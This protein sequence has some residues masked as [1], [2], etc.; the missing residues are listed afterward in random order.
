MK[1]T[2]LITNLVIALSIFICL[3]QNVAEAQGGQGVLVVDAGVLPNSKFYFLDRFDEWMQENIFTF[4]VSSLRVEAA[5]ANASERVAEAQILNAR[6]LL[7]KQL[8]GQILWGWRKDLFLAANIVENQTEKGSNPVHLIQQ[9]L[10]IIFLGKEALGEEVK[11]N[12]ILTSDDQ[13]KLEDYLW[14]TEEKT[15]SL[16]SGSD[17]MKLKSALETLTKGQIYFVEKNIT[18]RKRKLEVDGNNGKVQFAG[19]E[20]IAVAESGIEQVKKFTENDDYKNA[21]DAIG[22]VRSAIHLSGAGTLLFD[23]AD[24]SDGAATLERIRKA[25]EIITN[26][27][28]L[29]IGLINNA[30]KNLTDKL[31]IRIQE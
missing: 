13:S 26:S 2:R 25:E 29:D 14:E 11:D 23:E 12:I 1:N 6:G 21:L 28:L 20:M 17:D 24:D 7:S 19:S 9:T 18:E 27:G 8:A 3:G 16:I 22:D 30:R 4:G 31:K 10:D 5:M 15:L